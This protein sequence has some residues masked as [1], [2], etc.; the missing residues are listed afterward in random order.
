MKLKEKHFIDV[1]KGATGLY[2]LLLMQAYGTWGNVTSW[3]TWP[4][5]GPTGSCGF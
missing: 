4:Y 3:T 1:H 5:T 2:I